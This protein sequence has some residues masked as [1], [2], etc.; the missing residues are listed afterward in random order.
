M[1]QKKDEKR[2]EVKNPIRTLERRMKTFGRKCLLCS[3]ADKLRK[4]ITLFVLVAINALSLGNETQGDGGNP[5]PDA[6]YRIP[7]SE[8]WISLLGHKDAYH[9]INIYQT[10]SPVLL[11][12]TPLS[13]RGC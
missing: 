11:I 1:E 6:K 8:L 10:L 4:I 5:P 9:S 13:L 12:M 7:D 2:R 3:G